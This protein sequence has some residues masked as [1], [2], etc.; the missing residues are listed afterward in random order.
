MRKSLK[1]VLS[2]FVFPFS[3]FVATGCVSQKP[4]L[5]VHSDTNHRTFA[6]TF[7]Q[8]VA[9]PNED[10]TYHF[11]LVA[12]DVRPTP[13][14]HA[15]KSDP[16]P[17][18]DPSESAPLH[19]IV[20]VKVLWRPMDGT[21]HTVGSNAAVN[22]YVLSDTAAGSHDLLEYQGSAFVKV[23]PKDGVTKVT[24]ADGTLRPRAVRGGLSDPIGPASI[25]GSFT[26]VNDPV[27]LREVLN[28]TRARTA[29]AVSVAQ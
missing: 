6:Q 11:V 3:L 29:A 12:D 8:A 28:S 22:W 25:E 27:R 7:S 14:K 10:G 1:V 13:N 16:S 9:S 23:Y 26:A 4:T 20:Y 19:Q 2:F 5:V 24:I 17:R 21:D 15:K 18:I